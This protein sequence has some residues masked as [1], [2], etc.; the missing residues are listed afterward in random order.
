VVNLANRK[1]VIFFRPKK[2]GKFSPFFF[3][4]FGF[5][6]SFYSTNFAKFLEKTIAYLFDI[7]KL[8][9]KQFAT[10]RNCLWGYLNLANLK[11]CDFFGQFLEIIIIGKNLEIRGL[12]SVNSI[13]SLNFGKEK[14]RQIFDITK[15]KEKEKE[16]EKNPDLDIG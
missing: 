13:V 12:Y 9:K 7:T 10:E 8:K 16:K 15:C 5:L 2:A 4:F 14:T 3:L 1:L 11:F 6:S